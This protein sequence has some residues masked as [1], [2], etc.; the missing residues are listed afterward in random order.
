MGESIPEESRQ[1][2]V[3]QKVISGDLS[4]D[5]AAIELESIDAEENGFE[6]EE[7]IKRN[8]PPPAEVAEEMSSNLFR[9]FAKRERWWVVPYTFSVVLTV[10]SAIWLFEGWQAG[11]FSFGFWISWIPFLLGVS[12]MA[13]SWQSRVLRWI[14]IRIKNNGAK[15]PHQFSFSFPLPSRL[16]KWVTG[17]FGFA[18]PP[19]VRGVDLD[20][21]LDVLDSSVSDESPI[22][23]WFN[24]DKEDQQVEVWVGGN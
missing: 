22:Y 10:I 23:I 21:L 14:H 7:K 6:W 13:L 19:E 5:E 16:I 24:D 15:T 11:R 3:L 2:E 8:S 18:F 1:L 9:R 17:N 20:E 4:A 12:G